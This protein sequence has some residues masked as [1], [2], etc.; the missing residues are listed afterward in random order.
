MVDSLDSL[1]HE[2]LQYKMTSLNDAMIKFS[3]IIIGGSL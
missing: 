1:K 2:V 3:T